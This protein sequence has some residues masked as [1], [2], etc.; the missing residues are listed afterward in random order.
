MSDEGRKPHYGDK[1]V[2][3]V[4]RIPLPRVTSKEGPYAHELERDPGP[5]RT[6]FVGLPS[7]KLDAALAAKDYASSRANPKLPRIPGICDVDVTGGRKI[8]EKAAEGGHGAQLTSKGTE[9]ANVTI[10]VVAW[11]PNQMQALRDFIEEVQPLI[12]DDAK[13]PKRIARERDNAFAIDV[14]HPGMRIRKIHSILIASIAGPKEEGLTLKATFVAKQFVPHIK[15]KAGAKPAKPVSGLKAA[16]VH[17]EQNV[18]AN[19][20]TTGDY[21]TQAPVPKGPG[22]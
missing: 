10:T 9:L 20:R 19:G 15:A 16:E 12:V 1:S 4:G 17:D 3:Y 13:D 8:E 11:T 14:V 2:P 21:K 22:K 18:A 6:V 7:K 5:W